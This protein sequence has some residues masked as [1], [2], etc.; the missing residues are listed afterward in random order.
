[1][2]SSDWQFGFVDTL[3]NLEVNVTEARCRHS[4]EDLSRLWGWDGHIVTENI[5]L[6][7]L[8]IL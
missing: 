1:M 7:V 4:H 5:A 3:D 6:V 2:R 8:I